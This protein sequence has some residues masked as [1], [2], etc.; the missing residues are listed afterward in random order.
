MKDLLDILKHTEAIQSNYGTC[1]VWKKPVLNY[2]GYPIIRLDTKTMYAHRAVYIL[3]KEDNLL[4]NDHIH[5]ICENKL[6]LNPD[7][8]M[9]VTPQEHNK[10]RIWKPKNNYSQS[11]SAIRS[12]IYLNKKRMQKDFNS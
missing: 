1:L 12:R 8:L 11:P 9:K 10:L 2:K 6:C 7:H 3:T 5:H 4:S